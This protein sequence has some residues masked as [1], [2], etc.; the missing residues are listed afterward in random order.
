MTMDKTNKF[1]YEEFINKSKILF[2][3]IMYKKNQLYILALRTLKMS[4][5]D[6]QV[7]MSNY[8]MLQK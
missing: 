2:V 7:L 3:H 4:I 1:V 6:L 5:V 8:K